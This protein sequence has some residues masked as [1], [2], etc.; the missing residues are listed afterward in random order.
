MD[1]QTR[2][3]LSDALRG[4]IIGLFQSGT[5]HREISKMTGVPKST[6]GSTIKRW[7]KTGSETPAKRP[8]RPRIMK[9]RDLRKLE[10]LIKQNR[11]APL[12]I[13]TSEF[14]M[15]NDVK[16]SERTIQRTLRELRLREL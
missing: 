7:L 4:Q 2:H 9:E 8:G 13:I 11:N 14:N 16:V 12:R 1:P 3:E 10:R 15:G 6:V 5:T